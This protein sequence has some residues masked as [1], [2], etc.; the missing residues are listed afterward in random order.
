[1][2][3]F[4]VIQAA[5][6]SQRDTVEILLQAAPEC[7]DRKD[8]RGRVPEDLAANAEVKRLLS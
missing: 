6:R 8:S 3:H 2:V 7:R 5:E 1:M 4:D